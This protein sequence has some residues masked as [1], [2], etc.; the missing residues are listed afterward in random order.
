LALRRAGLNK[1]A[2]IPQA[3][4]DAKLQSFAAV[5]FDVAVGRAI[6]ERDGW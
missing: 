4:K 2:E 3:E 5:G 6:W 1:K